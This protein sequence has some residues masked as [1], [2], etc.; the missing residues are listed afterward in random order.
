MSSSPPVWRLKIQLLG[1]S[2]TVWRRLDTYADV[3][4]AQLHSFLQGG[5]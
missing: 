5:T 4:L 1:I 2:P 3:A